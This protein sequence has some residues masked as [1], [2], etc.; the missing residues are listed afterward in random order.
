V[1]NRVRER[2]QELGWTQRELA[3]RAG[4]SRQTIHAI[5]KEKYDPSLPL[6]FKL[7]AVLTVSLYDLFL[8]EQEPVDGSRQQ[9]TA[10][11]R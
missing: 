10:A 4:V 5:E 3:A 11:G 8:P 6:A 2:R 7:A 9:R 1:K